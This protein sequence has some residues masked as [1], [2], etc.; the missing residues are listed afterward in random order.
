M[1][2]AV[3]KGIVRDHGGAIHV[4]STPGTG[5][6][7]RV[8]LPCAERKPSENPF[9]IPSANLPQPG[10]RTA[11][12]LVVEDE[13]ALRTAVSKVLRR[14]GCSVMEAVDG[15]SAMEL[16]RAHKDELDAILLDVTLPGIS[17]REIFEEARRMR[18]DLRVVVTSA[19]SKESVGTPFNGLAVHQF[20]RK[21]YRLGDVVR[22]LRDTASP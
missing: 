15:R 16:L 21:P 20:I 12:I 22:L 17:S 10:A 4:A 2:L 5:T 1:G 3:V 8:L 18:H 7:F 9:A 11:K 14:T 13:E 19:Y 6:T